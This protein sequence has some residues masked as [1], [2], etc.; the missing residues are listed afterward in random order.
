VALDL[1]LFIPL[2]VL[3]NTAFPLPF[4]YVLLWFAAGRAFPEACAF[5]AVGSGCAGLAALVDLSVI[6]GIGRR[7]SERTGNGAP[8]TR[9]G[10]GFYVGAFLVALLP[11]PYTTI[12]LALLRVRPRPLIYALT[13]VAGRLPRYLVTLLLWRSL[14]LP[15]WV[16]GALVLSAVVWLLLARRGD[17]RD[18][19]SRGGVL[20]L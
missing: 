6:G 4:D 1:L 10:R 17:V 9:A 19:V 8:P 14:A 20:R 2:A 5:A 15:R 7:W 11:I 18:R 3:T 16:A 13:V 12:R